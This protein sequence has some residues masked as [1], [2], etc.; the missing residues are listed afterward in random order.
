MSVSDVGFGNVRPKGR[1]G[2]RAGDGRRR[3]GLN[4][5]TSLYTT[6][7]SNFKGSFKNDSSV[8]QASSINKKAYLFFNSIYM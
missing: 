8:K 4:Q 1:V 2:V 7:I 6:L 5:F 3:P